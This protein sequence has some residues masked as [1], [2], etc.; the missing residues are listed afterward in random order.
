MDQNELKTCLMKAHTNKAY[1]KIAIATAETF[2]DLI[3]LFPQI[4]I[5]SKLPILPSTKLS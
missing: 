1:G 5:E 4:I 2:L 3:N